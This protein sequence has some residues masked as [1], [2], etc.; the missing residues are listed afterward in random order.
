MEDEYFNQDYVEV[1]R[2]LEISVVTDLESEEPVTHY[3]VKWRGLPYE[4]STWELE[5]DV[6][7]A[8]VHSLLVWSFY[9]ITRT[10]KI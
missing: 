4:D 1:D 2:V 3:L 5:Q 9:K 10:Y 6:D 8:K 7:N